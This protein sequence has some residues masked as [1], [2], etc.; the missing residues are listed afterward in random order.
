M[1][2]FNFGKSSLDKLS[3]VHPELA[4][5]VV[6]AL[7]LSSVDF[8]IMEGKRSL[9]AQEQNVK[10]GVSKTLNSKH[11]AQADGYAWAVDL[12]PWIDGKAKWE[13]EP[14]YE[15]AEAM[16]KSAIHHGVRV[17]WG[18]FWGIVNDTKKPM[19]DIVNDY[20]TAMSDKGRKA[21]LDGP[22]F[23]LKFE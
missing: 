4:K 14:I 9:A 15:L 11:L 20:R 19:K 6:Y 10:K 8:T 5:V 22:H 23:E 7:E 16:R 21:F 12:V 13:W 18:G 2:K 3:E 17:R 1:G